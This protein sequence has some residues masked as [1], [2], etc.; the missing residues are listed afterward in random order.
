M[1]IYNTYVIQAAQTSRASA[2]SLDVIRANHF[3]DS[4]VIFEDYR[5]HE[6]P[7]TI[8]RWSLNGGTA[9]LG[10]V[11]NT[12]IASPPSSQ[13]IAVS[14]QPPIVANP[15]SQSIAVSSQP[16]IALLVPVLSSQP[17]P[18]D[19]P[20]TQ[21]PPK[22]LH[23]GGSASEK[24][25]PKQRTDAE[26]L[27]LSLIEEAEKDRENTRELARVMARE[28]ALDRESLKETALTKYN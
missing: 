17:I 11:G 2:E 7:A 23:I 19:D 6:R 20:S 14:S 25:R 22:A 4:F 28:K 26:Q 24:Y 8:P 9:E 5:Q 1:F 15:S 3:R 16:P 12:L 21:P 13:S 18:G 27:R 10:G